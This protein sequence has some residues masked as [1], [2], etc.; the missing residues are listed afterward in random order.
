MNRL[1]TFLLATL[2]PIQPTGLHSHMT[3]KEFIKNELIEGIGGIIDT[4]PF[5]AFMAMS[6][7]I[8]F[9]GKCLDVDKEWDD[10]NP[11]SNFNNAIGSLFPPEYQN[12]DLYHA[13]RCGMLHSCIPESSIAL[14]N[15]HDSFETI[16]I[17]GEVR[18]VISCKKLYTDFSKACDNVIKDNRLDKKTNTEF[19]QVL[20]SDKESTT[21]STYTYIEIPTK[22]NDANV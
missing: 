8:E 11:Q 18:T 16:T 22:K 10:R 6:A 19:Y 7:G 1:H 15:N 12:F 5:I 21:A 9:L 17:T 4:H 13:L 14:S 20:D 2:F 3:A